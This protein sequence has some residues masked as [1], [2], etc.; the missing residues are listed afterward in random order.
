MGHFVEHRQKVLLLVDCDGGNIKYDTVKMAVDIATGTVS[1]EL[2]G[3]NS[4]DVL[5]PV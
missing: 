3:R 5:T 2:I 4:A 1:V